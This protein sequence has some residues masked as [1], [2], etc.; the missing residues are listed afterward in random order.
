MTIKLTE[1]QAIDDS[2]IPRKHSSRGKKIQHVLTI[3]IGLHVN[4]KVHVFRNFNYLMETENRNF[5]SCTV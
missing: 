5:Q 3:T 4:E 2:I 1:R